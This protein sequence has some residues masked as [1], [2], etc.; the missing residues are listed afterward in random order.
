MKRMTAVS[1]MCMMFF[2]TISIDGRQNVRESILAGSWYPGSKQALHTE[3]QSFL[4]KADPENVTGRIFAIISPHAGYR[5]SGRAAAYGYKLLKDKDI[6]RVIVLAPSHQWGFRGASIL[7]VDAY[8]TPLGVVPVDKEAG[9]QLRTHPLIENIP[10]A[11][12]REHSLEIQLPFLQ[13]VLGE[14]KLVPLVIGQ[15]RGNDYSDI[16]QAIKPLLDDK[17]VVVVSSDFTHY[18]YNFS[19]IPFRDNVKNN[20]AKLDGGAVDTILNKNFDG[21]RSYLS[22]TGITICGKDP[23]CVLLQMLPENAD[24][25]KLIYYTSGDVTGDFVSSVSYVSIVFTVPEP[26]QTEQS[27][28]ET[29]NSQ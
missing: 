12:M 8:E 6:Q 9:D 13:E 17:T 10:Q 28:A 14:F 3:V 2:T 16:A 11:D 21:F 7:D 1:L 25:T 29:T 19:Y 15:L 5:Y 4:D 24:G 18:G 26:S 22:D 27:P 23:I 20:L